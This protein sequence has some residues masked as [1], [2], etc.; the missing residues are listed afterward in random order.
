MFSFGIHRRSLS[1]LESSATSPAAG[2]ASE[3]WRANWPSRPMRAE[4]VEIRAAAADELPPR[5]DSLGALLKNWEV[6]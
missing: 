5:E 2:A 1:S 4:S 6:V 3:G